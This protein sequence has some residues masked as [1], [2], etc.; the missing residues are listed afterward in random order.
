MRLVNQGLFYY[1]VTRMR[2]HLP[3]NAG[4]NLKHDRIF[5]FL[6]LAFFV[7]V[8]GASWHRVFIGANH[9]DEAAYIA[10]PFRLWSRDRPLIDEYW[11]SQF[12]AILLE[13]VVGAYIKGT[14]STDGIILFFRHLYLV[15]NIVT[16][17]VFIPILANC[18]KAD[19]PE[20]DFEGLPL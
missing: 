19:A 18:P 6:S 4:V 8:I 7:F 12:A 20:Q 9:T 15:F 14:G 1:K 13:P 3:D 5:L 2:N 11:I 17:L 16:A 10:M